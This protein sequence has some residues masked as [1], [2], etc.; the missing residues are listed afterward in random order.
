M[1][2]CSPSAHESADAHRGFAHAVPLPILVAVFAALCG[3]TFATVAA[4]WFDLGA[5]NLIVAM[6]IAT[7]KAGLVALYFMH[8][9][10]DHPFNALVL[11]IALG[12]LFL[13]LSVT[14]IDVV[15]YQ[16]DIESFVEETAK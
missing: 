2:D 3:L 12:F 11:A 14:L 8:L 6:A 1:H 16:P 7:V 10:Y 15:G 4:T 9:R 5:M 13:F